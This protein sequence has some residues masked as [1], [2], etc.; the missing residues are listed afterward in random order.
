MRVRAGLKILIDS[1]VN[2]PKYVLLSLYLL[3]YKIGEGQWPEK[4]YADRNK[5]VSIITLLEVLLL[6]NLFSGLFKGDI[7]RGKNI[8]FGT[9]F[10]LMIINGYIFLYHKKAEWIERTLEKTSSEVRL[11]LY[12]VGSTITLC[13]FFLTYRHISNHTLN[14]ILY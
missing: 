9:F 8:V 2:T 14:G 6:F 4:M 13:L 3:Y 12:G 7:V 1:V 10:I 11:T 5:A